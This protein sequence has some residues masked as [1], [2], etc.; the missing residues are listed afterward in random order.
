MADINDLTQNVNIWNDDKSKSVTVTTDGAKERLDVQ[1]LIEGG[2]FQLQAYA[3]VTNFNSTGVTLN[4]STWT[5]LLT[6]SAAGKLDFIACAGRTSS[7]RVRLTVE[8]N[9]CFD[10]SMSDLNLLGLSNAANVALWTETANK[11]FRY[12]PKTPVDFATSVLVEAKAVAFTPILRYL[13]AHREQ[14]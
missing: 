11:N 4:T 6:V 13:I 8:G 3:P 1:A 7:Y 12:H 2:T 10:I 9:V 5:T 14:I